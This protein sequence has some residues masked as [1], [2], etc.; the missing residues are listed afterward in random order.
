MCKIRETKNIKISLNLG[1]RERVNYLGRNSGAKSE[2]EIREIAGEGGGEE[3][4]GVV[5]STFGDLDH[6]GEEEHVENGESVSDNLG[7]EIVRSITQDF[8][9]KSLV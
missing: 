6:E 9:H 2:E 7:V 1:E 3:R 8:V 5:S 4:E